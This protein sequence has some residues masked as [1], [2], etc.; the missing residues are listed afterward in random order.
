MEWSGAQGHGGPIGSGIVPG[1]AAKGSAAGTDPGCRRQL[2]AC[3]SAADAATTLAGDDP[4]L[5]RTLAELA[6]LCGTTAQALALDARTTR[7][8]RLICAALCHLCAEQCSGRAEPWARRLA[9]RCRQCADACRQ[10]MALPARD[11]A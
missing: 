11:V 6:L 5:Q 10:V 4:E 2:A 9:R 1:R 8:L 7:E 3:A